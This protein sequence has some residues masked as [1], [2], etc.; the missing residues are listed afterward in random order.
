VCGYVLGRDDDASKPY[1]YGDSVRGFY[2][3]GEKVPSY[4]RLRAPSEINHWALPPR[5]LFIA[6][7]AGGN[8]FALTVGVKP[9]VRFVDHESPEPI[10]ERR[11][12]AEGFLDLLMRIRTIEE[13]ARID[14]EEKAESRR[15]LVEGAL[16]PAVE[17]QCRA[18]EREH[19]EVRAWI[20]TAFLSVFDAKGYFAVH[21]DEASRA[22][23]DLILWLGQTAGAKLASSSDVQKAL[24]STWGSSKGGLGFDGY[25]PGFIDDWWKSRVESGAIDSAGRFTQIAAR[26]MLAR[27]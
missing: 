16:P 7:D 19:P 27:Y 4:A 8:Q 26:Q 10:A 17:E 1:H 11:V 9:L 2:G 25:A 14:A 21:A 23:L 6:D 24:L 20:R 13:Q 5:T 12:L 18:V 22:V 15:V 3:L